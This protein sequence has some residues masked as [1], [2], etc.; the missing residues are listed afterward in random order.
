MGV[1]DI[2]LR[3]VAIRGGEKAWS[4]DIDDTLVQRE[5]ITRGLGVI[6][7]AIKPHL[8]PTFFK[9]S[10][11]PDMDHDMYKDS[12]KIK[13]RVSFLAHKKRT[14]TLETVTALKQAVETDI[15][16]YGNTGR[17]SKKDWVDM[18]EKQMKDEG[19]YKYLQGIFFTPKD[20]KGELSKAHAIKLLL[21]KYSE[22]THFDDDPRTAYYLAR[23][24]Q[25]EP[26]VKIQL[27]KRQ[28]AD[29]LFSFEELKK[30]PN[31]QIVAKIG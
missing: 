8:F 21:E 2:I 7:Q 23:V 19:L 14:S 18:T 6:G 12:L 31:L 30:F 10:E 24:F 22:V 15:D 29:R 28:L 3:K 4:L 11:I 27:V 1:Y 5:K 17:S 26:K 20:I 9:P 13:E 25:N 16:L